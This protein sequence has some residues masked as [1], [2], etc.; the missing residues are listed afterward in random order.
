MKYGGIHIFQL[1]FY[2][3]KQNLLNVEPYAMLL[4]MLA[5]GGIYY[6]RNNGHILLRCYQVSAI[7]HLLNVALFRDI[8]WQ[9][10]PIYP[11][12]LCHWNSNQV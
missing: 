12:P 6:R 2:Q 9:L 1:R 4:K 8:Y 11:N 7:L 5:C 3:W 10:F